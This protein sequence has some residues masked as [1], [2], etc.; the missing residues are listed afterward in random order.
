[1][2]SHELV[3]LLEKKFN[4]FS[5]RE[6]ILIGITVLAFIYF[7]WYTTLY[8]YVLATNEEISKKSQEI[9][10][11]I[12]S[13]EGQIDTLSGV[14]GRDPTAVLASQ[15]LNLKQ[16][17]EKLSQQIYVDTK[18]MVSPKEMTTILNNLIMQTVG[19][20]VLSIESL[21]TKPLFSGKTITENGKTIQFQVY[22]HGLQVE[23]M[24][25][26]FDT[27]QFL[28]ALEKQNMNVI[29]D[30][31]TYEVKKYPK[32]KITIIL[33]TLSLNEGWIDV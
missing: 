1:M 16:Q 33:H 15:A 22:N 2:N 30:E 6:R 31:I 17:S 20:T 19:L 23:M 9:K 11:Q 21:E 10:T 27:L 24:G 32:A 13:L 3:L 25:G 14:L 7:V 4:A 18:K 28:K 29:W 26:Y 5:L 8:D 12:N